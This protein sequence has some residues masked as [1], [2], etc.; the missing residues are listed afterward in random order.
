ML[1]YTNQVLEEGSTK[2]QT[3]KTTNYLQN[4]AFESFESIIL[5]LAINCQ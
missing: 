4:K 5:M 3:F 2:I 1:V